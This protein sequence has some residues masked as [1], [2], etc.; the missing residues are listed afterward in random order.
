[1]E[2]RELVEV[3]EDRFMLSDLS[4]VHE[5]GTLFKGINTIVH[6][7]AD[8]DDQAPWE[9][10]LKNN[11]EATQHLFEAAVASGVRRVIYASSIQVSFGY[12][13]NV[14]PYKSIYEMNYQDVPETFDRISVKAPT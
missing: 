7:A 1:M 12:F 10:T 3:P 5:L 14:E 6:M 13:R 4:N 9:S 8:P 2:Q 11:I